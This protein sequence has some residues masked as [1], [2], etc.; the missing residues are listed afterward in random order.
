MTRH[1]RAHTV[2]IDDAEFRALR[3][4]GTY[5]PETPLSLQERCNA[6]DGGAFNPALPYVLALRSLHYPLPYSPSEG[7]AAANHERD[8]GET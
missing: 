2:D 4:D 6:I 1:M 8:K 5:V 7:G 3:V